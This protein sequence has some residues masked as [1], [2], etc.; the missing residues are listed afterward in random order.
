MA[1]PIDWRML[2]VHQDVKKGLSV[3]LWGV[4]DVEKVHCEVLGL[5]FRLCG[6][7]ICQT[8]VMLVSSLKKSQQSTSRRQFLHAESE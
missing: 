3:K 1:V 2:F 8:S 4:L 6:L 5:R 7:R